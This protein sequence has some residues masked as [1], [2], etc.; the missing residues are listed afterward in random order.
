MI[1]KGRCLMEHKI[2]WKNNQNT[3]PAESKDGQPER[4]S[5]FILCLSQFVQ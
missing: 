2:H 1:S 5:E 4:K 3:E